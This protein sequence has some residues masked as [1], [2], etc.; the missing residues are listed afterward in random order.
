MKEAIQQ[1][2]DKFN[3]P[4]KP[5]MTY[6][7]RT[8]E[9]EEGRISNYGIE[10]DVVPTEIFHIES[11]ALP[12]DITYAAALYAW[13]NTAREL[14]SEIHAFM[15]NLM[16]GYDMTEFEEAN[17]NND[18]YQ[19]TEAI[20]KLAGESVVLNTLASIYP[21]FAAIA[22]HDER[23]MQ[24]YYRH[25]LPDMITQG[26]SLLASQK[27]SYLIKD[28]MLLETR[29]LAAASPENA[30]ESLMEMLIDECPIRGNLFGEMIADVLNE[31]AK[32][33]G[34]KKI[35]DRL[36]GIR[37]YETNPPETRIRHPSYNPEKHLDYI[38]ETYAP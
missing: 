8:G 22:I 1:V 10:W 33:K 16:K 11:N 26:K 32:E 25:I 14:P 5:P 30:T 21:S 7:L 6:R 13:Y 18:R 9:L 29:H 27:I 36:L 38:I 34:Y 4:I 3:L 17:K 24:D 2:I 15:Q 28:A 35:S 31:E 23:V 19:L 20:G 37:E 12:F